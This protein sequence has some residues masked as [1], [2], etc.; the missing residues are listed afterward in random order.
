MNFLTE[1]MASLAQWS[2]EDESSGKR[3]TKSG[4]SM[5]WTTRVRASQETVV[6]KVGVAGG[7]WILQ[8]VVTALP[9]L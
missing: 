5:S 9:L 8:P 1:R 4:M 2:G 3:V 7:W 6:S